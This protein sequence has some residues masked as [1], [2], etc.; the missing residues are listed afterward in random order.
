MNVA[1]RKEN[2]SGIKSRS[3]LGKLSQLSEMKKELSTGAVIQHK[4]NLSFD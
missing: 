2:L 4:V 1:N 3:R